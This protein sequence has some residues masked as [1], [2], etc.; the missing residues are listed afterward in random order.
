MFALSANDIKTSGEYQNPLEVESLKDR[1]F[2]QIHSNRAPEAIAPTRYDTH[3]GKTVFVTQE[4]VNEA[5]AEIKRLNIEIG[6]GL[7][8]KASAMLNQPNQFAESILA[9]QDRIWETVRAASAV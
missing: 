1:P 5:I 2:A 3:E 9:V 8:D 4:W 7:A 6:N